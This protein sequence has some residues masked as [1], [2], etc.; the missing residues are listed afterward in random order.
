M[1]KCIFGL[2]GISEKSVPSSNKS[3]SS[4]NQIT[5][6]A[7]RRSAVEG[8][9]QTFGTHFASP[10]VSLPCYKIKRVILILHLSFSIAGE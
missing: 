7:I 3:V 10:K 8:A 1:V 4:P 5:S 2:P 6:P 9:G